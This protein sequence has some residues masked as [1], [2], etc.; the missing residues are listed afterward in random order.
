LH[1]SQCKGTHRPAK[2]AGTEALR[3]NGEELRCR[4]I[5]CTL[6]YVGGCLPGYEPV[7][8]G[9]SYRASRAD[10]ETKSSHISHLSM[11]LYAFSTCFGSMLTIPCGMFLKVGAC[12]PTLVDL[13]RT[14]AIGA[15]GW[16]AMSGRLLIGR[17]GAPKCLTVAPLADD[18]N[19]TLRS[20][21]LWR[22][23]SNSDS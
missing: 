4:S 9:R 13:L 18:W 11:K 8:L 1:A 17:W 10:M 20:A 14:A 6:Y 21:S 15:H 2:R 12:T 3:H 19:Y 5:R 22:S 7:V 23:C 16:Y